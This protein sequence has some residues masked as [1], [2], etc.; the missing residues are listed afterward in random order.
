M[1][2]VGGF[3][4]WIIEL[5][6]FH[7]RYHENG[8]HNQVHRIYPK[9]MHLNS[10]ILYITLHILIHVSKNT[11]DHTAL[12]DS[13]QLHTCGPTQAV[14]QLPCFCCSLLFLKLY[15]R[16][17]LK[18]KQVAKGNKEFTRNNYWGSSWYPRERSHFPRKGNSS[19][20]TCLGWEYVS[21]LQGKLPKTS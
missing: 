18:K 2:F 14:L 4:S 20:Q 12:R 21:S 3:N 7:Q 5:L 15:S 8:S 13:G 19:T 17:G 11:I 10:I 9:L 6:L 1:G 16:G